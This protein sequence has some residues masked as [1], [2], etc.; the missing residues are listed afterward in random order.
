MK[1]KEENMMCSINS[2]TITSVTTFRFPANTTQQPKKRK[3]V[4]LFAYHHPVET[5]LQFDKE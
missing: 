2:A 4:K 1:K 3:E 5:F